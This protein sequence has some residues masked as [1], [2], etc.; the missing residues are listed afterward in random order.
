MGWGGVKVLAPPPPYGLE[1]GLV[2]TSSLGGKSSSLSA[3]A[4][5]AH[6]LAPMMPCNISM[7]R[8]KT[9]VEFFSAA[10]VVSV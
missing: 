5:M 9:M 8:G 7:G 3:S 10:M 6:F 2:P 1:A 4:Y